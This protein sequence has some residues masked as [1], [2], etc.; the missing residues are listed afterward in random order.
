MKTK[1]MKGSSSKTVAIESLVT[2]PAEFAKK[3]KKKH[4]GN[5]K[6]QLPEP[7]RA[8]CFTI[9]LR[10]KVALNFLLKSMKQSWLVC[11]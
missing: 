4:K 7:E 11:K 2:E 1:A 6:A 3:K 10:Q 9:Y 8:E 5:K